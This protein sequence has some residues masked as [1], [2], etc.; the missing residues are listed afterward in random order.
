VTASAPDALFDGDTVAV[1]LAKP[2]LIFTRVHSAHYTGAQAE[3]FV[4]PIWSRAREQLKAKR[5]VWVSD[6]RAIARYD[7]R[8]RLLLTRWSLD[9]RAELD[10]ILFLVSP[11]HRMVAAG[12]RVGCLANAA[13]GIPAF[14]EASP[15]ALL[16]RHGVRWPGGL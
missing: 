7:M 16:E 3:T 13:L 5:Y 12:I 11:Q 14:V 9:H 8:S 4:G 2:N 1:W 15:E 6:S 10:R